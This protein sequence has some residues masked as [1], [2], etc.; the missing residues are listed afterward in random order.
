M[1]FLAEYIKTENPELE[2]ILLDTEIFA[3][4]KT[5][6][7]VQS[8]IIKNFSGIINYLFDE[9]N[10]LNDSSKRIYNLPFTASEICCLNLKEINNRLLCNNENDV[11][12]FKE[13]FSYIQKSN[14]SQIL[15]SILTNYSLKIIKKIL[16]TN[17][18]EFLKFFSDEVLFDKL[19]EC[20]EKIIY[21]DQAADVIILLHANETESYSLFKNKISHKFSNVLSNK[22]QEINEEIS[23]L[24]KDSNPNI[25]SIGFETSIDFDVVENILKYFMK[26]MK[27]WT[28][29]EK[30]YKIREGLLSDVIFFDKSLEKLQLHLDIL[31]ENW[32]L[33]YE[34]WEITRS[35]NSIIHY[36]TTCIIYLSNKA[37]FNNSKFE[38]C[39]NIFMFDEIMDLDIVQANSIN[40]EPSIFENSFLTSK[41]DATKHISKLIE[42]FYNRCF[43]LAEVILNLNNSKRINTE[44]ILNFIDFTLLLLL[45]REIIH[46]VLA[47]ECIDFI[48]KNFRRFRNNTFYMSKLVKLFELIISN[49]LNSLNNEKQYED[50]NNKQT[51]SELNFNSRVDCC[52]YSN[53]MKSESLT[54]F[55]KDCD[56][57]IYVQVDI[58]FVNE[59][60]SQNQN[61]MEKYIYKNLSYKNQDSVH[62]YLI[63]KQLYE[64]KEDLKVCNLESYKILFDHEI[65][66]MKYKKFFET[67]ITKEKQNPD[68]LKF[69][70]PVLSTNT[71]DIDGKF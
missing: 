26:Q 44:F 58:K 25:I 20:L 23:K 30:D 36:I 67:E 24:C 65:N 21:L 48:I 61:E 49:K 4:I 6:K 63:L 46:Q 5:D 40:L 3:E 8:Y 11:C 28:I 42:L 16:R 51:N 53:L 18:K 9:P 32:Y 35:A 19:I 33:M 62:V 47:Y 29:I 12:Y 1:S 55:L 31:I 34:N 60:E 41:V 2:E 66:Y 14:R 17:F 39:I 13:F 38:D 50:L 70:D 15:N 57:S 71:N 7:F 45:N 43:K 27:V 64:I 59:N 56:L 68:I 69:V 54:N 52:I 10:L 37:D 22:L